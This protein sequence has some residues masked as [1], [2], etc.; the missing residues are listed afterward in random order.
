METKVRL[1][2]AMQVSKILRIK[3]RTVY[4]LASRRV[5][6]PVRLSARIIRFKSSEIVRILGEERQGARVHES[7]SEPRASRGPVRGRSNS[8]A[9]RV[10]AGRI[11]A[12]GT[13]KKGEGK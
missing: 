8:A 11:T 6:N 12:K 1:L 9:W 5:L 2:T 10:R 4:S 3:P 7:I 13:R